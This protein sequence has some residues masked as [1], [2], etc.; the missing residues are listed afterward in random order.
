MLLSPSLSNFFILAFT[1]SSYRELHL[2]AMTFFCITVC[3]EKKNVV[4]CAKNTKYRQK[5]LTRLQ[6]NRKRSRQTYLKFK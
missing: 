5:L 4:N 1:M 6:L 3:N 2:Q